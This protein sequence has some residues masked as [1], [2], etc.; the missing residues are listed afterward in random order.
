[1]ATEA[2]LVTLP[3]ELHV[4]ISRH[5]PYPDALSLKHTSRY[6]YPLVDTGVPLKVA[7]LIERRL[8][9]LECPSQGQCVLKSDAQFCSRGVRR[10]MERRRR[11]EECGRGQG[12]VVGGG[13]CRKR[14]TKIADWVARL[15]GHG[16]GRI[17]A[18]EAA[19]IAVLLAWAVTLLFNTPTGP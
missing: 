5:L 2:N 12:C 4:A 9:H 10:L 8:L 11:H 6:F 1:M 13:E 7:W 15:D 16:E 17:W 14:F 18:F 3:A 19:I